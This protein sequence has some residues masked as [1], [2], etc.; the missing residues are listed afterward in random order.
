VAGVPKDFLKSVPLLSDVSDNDLLAIAQGLHRRE[1][2]PGQT[3]TDEGEDG[4]G[5]WIIESGSASVSLG[6]RPIRTLG[7]GD[8][9]GEIALLADSPRTATVTAGGNLVSWGMPAWSF[10]PFVTGQPSV[11]LKLLQGLARQLV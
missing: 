11:A 10:T 8:Y 4:I 6:D 7:P 9:F 3:M 1:C 2:A 5:F